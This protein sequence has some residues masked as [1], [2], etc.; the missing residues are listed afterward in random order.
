MNMKNNISVFGVIIAI[1]IVIRVL[2]NK[3]P[4]IVFVVALINLIA[5]LIVVFSITV[6]I[7]TIITDKIMQSK[8]PE[9]IV[10]REKRQN[11]KKVDFCI[12]IPLLI[13]Y[14]VYLIYFCSELG[15]DIISILALGLSLMDSFIADAVANLCIKE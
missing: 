15:N 8:V 14:I 10:K 5:L 7:K 11:Y 2:L 12:Y 1:L 6:Q 9:D 4:Q 3:N 13:I